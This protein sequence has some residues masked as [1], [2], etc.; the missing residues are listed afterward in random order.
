MTCLRGFIVRSSTLLILAYV[1]A[2]LASICFDL[3]SY[4]GIWIKLLQLTVA[5]I[6]TLASAVTVLM[7]TQMYLQYILRGRMLSRPG[8]VAWMMWFVAVCWLYGIVARPIQRYGGDPWYWFD[9]PKDGLA[10]IPIVSLLPV[11]LAALAHSMPNEGDR[12]SLSRLI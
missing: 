9:N 12:K 5:T 1:A 6:G 10:L 8:V 7:V 11:I 4:G 3:N 2:A